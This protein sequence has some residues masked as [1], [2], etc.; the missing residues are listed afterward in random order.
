LENSVFIEMESFSALTNEKSL[1]L[2]E[3]KDYPVDKY[4]D[5]FMINMYE[6]E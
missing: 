4:R 3:I 6:F 5:C 1:N 2:P